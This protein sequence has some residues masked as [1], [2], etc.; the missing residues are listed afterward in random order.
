[1]RLLPVLVFAGCATTPPAEGPWRDA[2][3][4]LASDQQIAWETTD[5]SRI[6]SVTKTC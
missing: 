2:N 6:G 3:P 4:G 5:A 1:M